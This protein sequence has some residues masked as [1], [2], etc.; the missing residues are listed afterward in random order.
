MN[1]VTITG[2]TDRAQMT[3]PEHWSAEDIRDEIELLS[4]L[5]GKD[6]VFAPNLV[7]T[8]N[9]YDGSMAE[10]LSSAVGNIS[11]TLT[12]VRFIDITLWNPGGALPGQ[13][14]ALDGRAVTY[15]HVSPASGEVLRTT[16]WLFIE[17]GLAVQATGT[18]AAPDWMA[19]GPELEQIASSLVVA[20]DAGT[21]GA[22]VRTELPEGA[23]DELA[24][25]ELGA[26]VESISGIGRTQTFDYA[27]AWVHAS[28]LALLDEMAEGFRIG[29]LNAD[30]Y[31]DQLAELESAGLAQGTKLTDTGEYACLHLDEPDASFRISAAGSGGA[32]YYQAWLYGPTALVTAGTGYHTQVGLQADEAPSRDHVNVRIFPITE[33]AREMAS[34][35]GVGPAWPLPALPAGLPAERLEQ[36]W[37][38]NTEIPETANPV[39]A[40]LW[41][42]DWFTW[43]LSAQGPEGEIDPVAYLNGGPLGHYR[44]GSED[45]R[46]W[47]MPTPSVYLYDQLDDLIAAAIY[48]RPA[49][50]R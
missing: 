32:M 42:Q 14:P 40:A 31:R 45:G 4:V 29:R 11:Q 30:S 44:L 22:P 26:P 50:L 36:R 27:G 48:G 24:S 15:T 3:I 38:G 21:A 28:A 13:T 6:G 39:L 18:T 33:L 16:D 34:W 17:N 5:K 8:L 25:G 7:V 20:E 10:F 43:E 23:L 12:E 1:T 2:R 41:E 47:L 37:A 46:T 35:L 49:R 19:L 9:A